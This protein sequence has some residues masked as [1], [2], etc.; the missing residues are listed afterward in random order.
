MTA[1]ARSLGMTNTTF[2]NASGLPNP[3]QI[4]T[5]RDMLRLSQALYSRFPRYYSFFRT[6]FFLFQGQRHKNHNHLLGQ[7]PGVDGIKTGF[8]NASGFNLA[9]SAKRNGVRLFVVVMGGQTWQW[10][11]QRVRALLDAHFPIALALY[12]NKIP[13]DPPEAK[14]LEEFP[15]P[16][17]DSEEPTVDEEMIS[18]DDAEEPEEETEDIEEETTPQEPLSQ[19]PL[20]GAESPVL[21]EVPAAAPAPPTPPPLETPKPPAP[22][23]KIAPISKS[24]PSPKGVLQL[25]AFKTKAAAQSQAKLLLK[26]LPR[27]PTGIEIGRSSTSKKAMYRLRLVGLSKAQSEA[28]TKVLKKKKLNYLVLNTP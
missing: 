13:E 14:T 10:R 15:E 6:K 20:P 11:D 5:A 12:K 22:K 28:L 9:A 24:T 21:E 1:K 25:G 19:A 26:V 4:T 3:A 18:V 2:K 16:L 7:C 8:V 23:A 17:K 27:L